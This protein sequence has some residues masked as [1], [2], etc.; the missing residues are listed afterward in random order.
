MNASLKPVVLLL[1]AALSSSQFAWAAAPDSRISEDITVTPGRAISRAD[2]AAIS[3]VALR[4]MNRIADARAAIARKDEAAARE[5]LR[6]ADTLLDII[7]A[8]LPTT[9]VRDQIRL[10]QS[11]LQYDQTSEVRPDL[12]PIYSALD[13][14]EDFANAPVARAHLDHAQA[15]L[16]AGDAA[17]AKTELEAVDAALLYQEVDLPLAATRRF[18]HAAQAELAR[19]NLKLAGDHLRAAQDNVVYYTAFVDEPLVPA[20]ANLARAQANLKAGR[21]DAARADVQRAVAQLDR[22]AARAD[23]NVKADVQALQK[24]AQALE[25]KIGQG[26]DKA[27]SDA[28]LLWNRTRA[29]AERA[30]DYTATG[31]SRLRA[32]SE[33]KKSLIEAKLHARYADIDAFVGSDPARAQTDLGEVARYLEQARGVKEIAPDTAQRIGDLQQSLAAMRQPGKPLDHADLDALTLRIG[34]TLRSL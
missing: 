26:G 25:R 30:M 19:G 24:D 2:E 18:V 5:Q 28:A 20:K 6:Q 1:T 16:K 14:I 7:E 3:R 13:E 12:V 15:K 31:W 23:A 27:E 21:V 33:L 9:R 17:G 11:K 22:A 4:T 34:Q 10:A 8:A 32:G 29:L